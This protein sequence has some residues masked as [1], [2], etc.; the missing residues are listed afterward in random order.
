[1]SIL[2]EIYIQETLF[3]Y[4]SFQNMFQRKSFSLKDC[5]TDITYT[6]S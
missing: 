1:M 5:I 4:I 3:N 6:Q 2:K